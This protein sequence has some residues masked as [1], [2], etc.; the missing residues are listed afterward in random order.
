MPHIFIRSMCFVKYHL[1]DATPLLAWDLES[2]FWLPLSRHSFLHHTLG[3]TSCR[4][5]SMD[6]RSHNP[7]GLP[8]QLPLFIIRQIA[9]V[10]PEMEHDKCPFGPSTDT[11]D[12][13]R[14][15]RPHRARGWAPVHRR[16]TEAT[17]KRAVG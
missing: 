4:P 12:A 14:S 7:A 11:D 3:G 10:L 9:P 6:Q 17:T 8:P 15:H 1:D 2:F 16:N 13:P 5:H